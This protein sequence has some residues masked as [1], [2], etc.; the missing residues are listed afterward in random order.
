MQHSQAKL[1]NELLF[2]IYD[3]IERRHYLNSSFVERQMFSPVTFIAHNCPTR[4]TAA[5]E[6]AIFI[7]TMQEGRARRLIEANLG[8]LT[9]SEFVLLQDVCK[10]VFQLTSDLGQPAVPF[11]ALIRNFY[12]FRLAQTFL[13]KM[14]RVLEVGPG[15]GY[16]PILLATTGR[17]V[18]ATDITQALFLT[19]HVLYS[20]FELINE[21][22]WGAPLRSLP[23]E[24]FH[25]SSFHHIPWWL[26]KDLDKSKGS[27]DAIIVNCAICEFHKWAIHHLLTVARNL[28]VR[29]F[30]MDSTGHQAG[31]TPMQKVVSIF[32]QYEFSLVYAQNDVYVFDRGEAKNVLPSEIVT[33]GPRV[34]S[35]DKCRS[36]LDELTGEVDYLPGSDKFIERIK[37]K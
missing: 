15:S 30:L 13:P 18:A 10:G 26:F 5:H 21:P 34:V 29:R 12:Q 2:E 31:T 23:D 6:I 27:I 8:G 20:R 1:E 25:G 9:A 28:G 19:Q 37:Y 7:D 35:F 14:D 11:G 22:V 17:K 4:I 3:S 16:L 24:L 32:S 33:G 36:F